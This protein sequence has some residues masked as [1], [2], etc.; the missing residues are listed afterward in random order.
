M[1]E[2]SLSKS[3]G[4]NVNYEVSASKAAFKQSFGYKTTSKNIY[5]YDKLEIVNEA[6]CSIYDASL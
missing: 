3:F 6:H 5:T 2:E 1:G 4:F